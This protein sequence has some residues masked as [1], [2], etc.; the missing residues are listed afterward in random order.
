MNM[1]Q[2]K[3]IQKWPVNLHET[4]RKIPSILHYP[5]IGEDPEWGF[6]C[7]NHEHKEWFKRYLD[8]ELLDQLS[9]SGPYADFPSAHQVR[10]RCE[11]YMRCLYV[12]IS[13]VLQDQMGRWEL[14][15]VEFSFQ[16]THNIQFTSH[17]HK[18]PGITRRGWIRKTQSWNRI[19]SFGVPSF[20]RSRE[21]QEWNVP[22]EILQLPMCL[23][24]WFPS[25]G[26]VANRIRK[27][28]LEMARWLSGSKWR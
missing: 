8:T 21:F 5:N 26:S 24:S 15:R 14:K 9:A 6:S 22:L 4:S 10:K 1:P 3:V 27:L 12:Y 28:S 20:G 7:Q 16:P 17:H 11:Y 13:R 2:P 18:P 19:W 25:H 23:S